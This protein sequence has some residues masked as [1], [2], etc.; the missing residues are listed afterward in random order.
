[1]SAA[2][3]MLGHEA[4]SYEA[5]IGQ[6][7]TLVRDGKEIKLSKRTGTMVEVRELIEAVGPD[8]ARFAYLLQSIDTR[9]TIDID[10]LSSQANENP[11]YYIQYAYARIASVGREAD[12]RGV[13]RNPLS[14]ID[15]TLL[16]HERELELL[17]ALSTLPDTI[18]IAARD[19]APH[20]ISTWIRELAA[21]FHGFYHDCPVLRSDVESDLQQARLWLVE[22]ARIGFSIG[23]DL[24]G[25]TA[26]EEM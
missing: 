14:E 4:S 16:T 21:V 13:T 2:L 17:R 5:I 3:Q 26:P 24:L 23:L 1:M 11:V 7:V 25:L 18:E 19:R 9:Q 22:S 6:N 10:V 8:V 20:K 15:P 12:K